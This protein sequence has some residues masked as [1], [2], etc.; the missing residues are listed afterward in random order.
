LL[1]CFPL[2]LKQKAPFEGKSNGD[3]RNRHH[4]S[5]FSSGAV[6]TPSRGERVGMIKNEIRHDPK[7]HKVGHPSNLAIFQMKVVTNKS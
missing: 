3:W 1:S 7:L 4:L 2:N 6:L 5:N